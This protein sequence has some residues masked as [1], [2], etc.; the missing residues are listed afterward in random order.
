[1]ALGR[2]FYQRLAAGNP[3]RT[4]WPQYRPANPRV[5]QQEGKSDFAQ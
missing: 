4:F 3:I 2:L 1:M 5:Q